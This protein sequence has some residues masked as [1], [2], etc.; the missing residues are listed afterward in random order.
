MQTAAEFFRLGQ[1]HSKLKAFCRCE[2]QEGLKKALERK[3]AGTFLF[4]VC[5]EHL[6]GPMKS[7]AF[8]QLCPSSKGTSLVPRETMGLKFL[9]R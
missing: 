6:G 7:A 3:E 2:W 1:S 8:R 9:H 5:G 4:A